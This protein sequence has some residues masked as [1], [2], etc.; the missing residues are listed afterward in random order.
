MGRILVID[1]EVSIRVTFGIHLSK[2]GHDVRLAESGEEAMTILEDWTPDVVVSDILM[3]GMTGMDVLEEM[4]KRFPDVQVIMITA[5]PTVDTA[6]QALRSK[7]FDYLSKPVTAAALRR[8]VGRA[9]QVKTLL[10]R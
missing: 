2:D 7:A 9:Y 3:P 1:D 4:R 6:S 5:V 8:V 10:D